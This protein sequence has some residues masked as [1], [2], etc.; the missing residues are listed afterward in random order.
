MLTV[1]INTRIVMK[2]SNDELRRLIQIMLYFLEEA[3]NYKV[4]NSQLYQYPQRHW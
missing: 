4:V 3:L 1:M 2:K